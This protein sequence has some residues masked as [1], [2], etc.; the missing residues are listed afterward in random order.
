MQHTLVTK[1]SDDEVIAMTVAIDDEEKLRRSKNGEAS[2]IPELQAAAHAW[3]VEHSPDTLMNDI[4]FELSK[5]GVR[6]IWNAPNY[7]WGDLVEYCW[8]QGKGYGDAKYYKGRTMA[9][10]AEHIHEE[11]YTAKE[12]SWGVKHQARQLCA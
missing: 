5:P 4:E 6:V 11:F 12:A 10:L 7:P 2:R 3:L 8:S 9:E 1:G